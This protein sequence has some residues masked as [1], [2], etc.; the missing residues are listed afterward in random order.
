MLFS[1]VAVPIY[2]PTTCVKGV[3]FFTYCR[4]PPRFFLMIDLLTGVRCYLIVVLIY[5][6]LMLSHAEHLFISLIGHPGCNSF[7]EVEL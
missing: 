5:I 2:S 6:S 7:D 1:R 3:P 4:H